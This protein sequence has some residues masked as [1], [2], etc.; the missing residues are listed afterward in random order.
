[1]EKLAVCMAVV[2]YFAY[3]CILQIRLMLLAKS[4]REDNN[5]KFCGNRL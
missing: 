4:I 1:M 2:A 3:F 5:E